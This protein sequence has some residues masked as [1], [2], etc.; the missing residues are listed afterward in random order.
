MS[1]V[2]SNP[3]G[4]TSDQGQSG[5]LLVDEPV[6]GVTR[7]TISNPLKRGALNAVMIE[8]FAEIFL[9]LR[10]RCVIITGEGEMFSAGC[11]LDQFSEE[12]EL[13]GRRLFEQFDFAADAVSNYSGTTIAALNGHAIG[14]GLELALTCDLL[15]GVDG[16][17]L[18]MPPAKLGLVYSSSG[19]RK[20]IDAIGTTRT[21]ELFLLGAPIDSG[22]GV[23]W[24]LLNRVVNKSELGDAVLAIASQIVENPAKGISGNKRVIRTIL[25]DD[26]G[27]GINREL[28]KLRVASLRSD[29]F[30]QRLRAF[31]EKRPPRWT[32]RQ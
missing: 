15:I 28:E 9:N 19:I 8:K 18:S 14:A 24:G 25:D 29:E 2:P 16:I 1:F 30:R 7:I 13:T 20:F 17:S 26:R 12:G 32:D 31:D 10:A 3:T 22:T 4:W 27:P 23:Q 5:R 6:P 11:D 21:R